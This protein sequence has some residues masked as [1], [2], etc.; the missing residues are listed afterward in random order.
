MIAQHPYW[1]QDGRRKAGRNGCAEG[2]APA[3]RREIGREAARVRWGG[4]PRKAETTFWDASHTFESL[5]LNVDLDLIL[6]QVLAYDYVDLHAILTIVDVGIGDLVRAWI[7][8]TR[9]KT[10]VS[11]CARS[12]TSPTWTRRGCPRCF[13]RPRGRRSKPISKSSSCVALMFEPRRNAD[14]V[15]LAAALQAVAPARKLDHFKVKEF[16]S[17]ETLER[18]RRCESRDSRWSR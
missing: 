2:L 12:A 1:L 3:R 16:A 5:N 11:L 6:Y 7:T 10:S 8:S 9:A 18:T 4:L 13:P 14:P 17:L 15:R